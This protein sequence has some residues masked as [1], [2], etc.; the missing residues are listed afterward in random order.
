[1]KRNVKGIRWMTIDCSENNMEINLY[2]LLL[3]SDK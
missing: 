2:K 1:M 3:E